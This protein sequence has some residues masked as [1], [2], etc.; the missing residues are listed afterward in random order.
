MREQTKQALMN[1]VEKGTEP[2]AFLEAVLCNDLVNAVV[3]A[4]PTNYAGLKDIVLWVTT[5]APESSWGSAAKV[6]SWL[7][8]HPAR[9]AQNT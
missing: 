6:N 5:Q 4:D 8:T 1:Y 3:L 9:L 2:D 7:N